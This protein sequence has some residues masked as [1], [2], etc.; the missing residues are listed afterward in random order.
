VH[1]DLWGPSPVASIGRC[2]YYITFT[3]DH[4]QY[5][6]LQILCT[7][8][9]ALDAYK[10][11]VVWAQTQHRAWIKCLRPDWGGE[12][13]GTKFTKFLQEQGTKCRLTT[14]NTP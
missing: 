6:H 9:Q 10:A 8:D 12:Y 11:F 4:T 2:K 7:K 5:T 14:H 13:T 3:D 1:T